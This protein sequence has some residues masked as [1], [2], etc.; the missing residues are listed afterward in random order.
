[1][2]KYT[3]NLFLCFYMFLPMMLLALVI[4]YGGWWADH[5]GNPGGI[6]RAVS[7]FD[8]HFT[9]FTALNHIQQIYG[10]YFKSPTRKCLY[11]GEYYSNITHHLPFTCSIFHFLCTIFGV[12]CNCHKALVS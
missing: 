11:S 8:H 9:A 7:S 1:M 12:K 2:G 5:N 10:N 3:A 4:L 6:T